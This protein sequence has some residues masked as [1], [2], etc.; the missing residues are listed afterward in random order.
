MFEP[1]LRQVR[2]NVIRNFPRYFLGPF[3]RY[4]KFPIDFLL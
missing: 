2:M 3:G 4:I 1:L